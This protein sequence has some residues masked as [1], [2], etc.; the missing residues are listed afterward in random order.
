MNLM[1]YILP[2]SVLVLAA[3]WVF[4]AKWDQWTRRDLRAFAR[5]VRH[6]GM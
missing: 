4:P 1:S 2:A 6:G 5:A 3:L